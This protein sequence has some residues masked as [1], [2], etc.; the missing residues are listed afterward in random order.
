M[1]REVS[2]PHSQDLATCQ[3]RGNCEYFVTWQYLRWWVVSNSPNPRLEDHPLS[4]VCDCLFN[5]FAATL[6][7]GGC[8]SIR[9]LMTLNPEVTGNQFEIVRNWNAQVIYGNMEDTRAWIFH[10][11]DIV[12]A[13][14]I[15]AHMSQ[16]YVISDNLQA[17]RGP[18]SLVMHSPHVQSF[19]TRMLL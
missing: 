4:D 19:T 13:I 17:T 11:A 8:S 12:H 6:R 5:I 16:L 18:V 1:I 3:V 2:L 9:K 15:S 10:T 14:I 7:I